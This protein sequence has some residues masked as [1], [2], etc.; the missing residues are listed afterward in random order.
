MAAVDAWGAGAPVWAV[1]ALGMRVGARV[2]PLGA[3]LPARG[4]GLRRLARA[5]S[6]RLYFLHVVLVEGM[7]P[8]VTSVVKGWPPDTRSQGVW[9]WCPSPP[10]PAGEGGH[11]QT[12]M[13]P[14]M[15]RGAVGA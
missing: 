15:V 13:E 11:Q 2:T 8:A 1:G 14:Q 7:L 5:L 4:R 9:P 12:R 3:L 10:G 6:R